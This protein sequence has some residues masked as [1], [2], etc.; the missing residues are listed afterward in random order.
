[1]RKIVYYIASSIDGFIAGKN[2]DISMFIQQSTGL[3]QYIN[4]LKDFDTVIMGKN[5]YEFGYKFG[6][7]PGDLA[8]PH[9]EH[10]VFSNDLTITEKNNKL[11]IEKID[12]A[13]IDTLKSMNGSDIYLCGGATFAGW[14]FDNEKIDILKIKLNPIILGEGLRLFGSS[15]KNCNL[16]LLSMKSYSN[17]LSIVE[18]KIHY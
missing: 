14:L 12:I 10:Y 13:K 18:Y 9:M 6:L 7:K 11:H 15:T 2:N 1:M 5:T 4:D 3:E 8:Y 16:E 17:S